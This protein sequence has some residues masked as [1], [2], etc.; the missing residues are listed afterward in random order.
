MTARWPRVG[1]ETG[2]MDKDIKA[3]LAKVGFEV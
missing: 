1:L 2:L 3:Q